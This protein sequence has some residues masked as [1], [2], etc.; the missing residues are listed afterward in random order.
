M[1][2]AF[3]VL[4][5]IPAADATDEGTVNTEPTNAAKIGETEYDTIANAIDA[6]EEKD[7]IVLLSDVTESIV[8][9]STVTI[10]LNGFK[11]KNDTSKAT[12]AVEKGKLIINDSKG[13]GEVI[14]NGTGSYNA[15]L[16]VKPGA[17]AE[18][19]GGFF[20][21]TGD[22][23]NPWYTLKNYGTLTINDGVKVYNNS[24]S[25]SVIANGYQ[26]LSDYNALTGSS[27]SSYPESIQ[28]AVM[29][30]NG[31]EFIGKCYVK[32]GILELSCYN[33]FLVR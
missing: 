16:I 12:I 1:A 27:C 18:L 26:N 15:A 10:D 21:S 13:N 17:E 29:T 33:N 23:G 32:M 19:N 7:T 14:Q 28:A 31:G 8:I 25:S 4:A 22:A 11:L 9:G 6:A 20:N 24:N 3:V 5:A 30:I 2:V